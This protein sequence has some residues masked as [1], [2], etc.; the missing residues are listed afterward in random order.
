M[1][2]S[3]EEG[4]EAYQELY[5]RG[6]E[7]I[8]LKEPMIDSAA[9]RQALAAS[10][11]LLRPWL[12]ARRKRRYAQADPAER[13]QMDLETLLRD[14]RG[15]G[16][17]RAPEESLRQYFERLPGFL[18][19]DGA[20]VREMAALYDRTFFA[21]KAPSEAE[22]EKHRAFAA[23]FRPRTLRQWITWYSLQ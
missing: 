13:L 6:V 11:P 8:Y 9:Y 3:A 23:Y 19:R 16:Y 7:L 10:V 17:P 15:K 18:I 12:R 2:R 22:L 21:L 1:S 5:R 20:E 4:Y 14:L